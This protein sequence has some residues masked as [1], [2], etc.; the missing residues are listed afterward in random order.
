MDVCLSLLKPKFY[1]NS[2]A[3]TS[4]LVIFKTHST[5][6]LNMGSIAVPVPV[7]AASSEESFE[8]SPASYPKASTAPLPEYPEDIKRI[9]SQ[10][11]NALND[12]LDSRHYSTLHSLLHTS[13]AYWRD[14]LGLCTTKLSTLVGATEIVNFI[15][16]NGPICPI[17]N[18]TLEENKHP[19]M[20]KV[21]PPGMI[22][23]VQAFITFET[24]TGLGRGLIS[25]VQD[26]DDGDLWKIFTIYTVLSDLKDSPF[27]TGFTRPKYANPQDVNG[28]K[29]W[30][31]F[32]EENL[33][34]E[35][36]EPTVLI[37]GMYARQ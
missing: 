17:Q 31:V 4:Y 19:E 14:H 5:L 25:W 20:G 16:D 21:D 35:D 3:D 27:A 32:R 29:N 15:H 7:R 1:P 8:I 12:L 18:F 36:A 33:D 9:A 37:V 11:I 2:I 28:T 24:A 6:R 23:T 26:V 22:K 34:F 10:G 13:R 30:K